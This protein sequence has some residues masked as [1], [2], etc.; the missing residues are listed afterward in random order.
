MRQA[1]VLLFVIAFAAIA[2]AEDKPS[3]TN[4]AP[5]TDSNV[6]NSLSNTKA[7]EVPPSSFRD[8]QGKTKQITSLKER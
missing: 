6:P 3:S 4:K 5:R 1:L 7:I 2:L 8:H